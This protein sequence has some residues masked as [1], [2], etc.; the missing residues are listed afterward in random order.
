MSKLLNLIFIFIIILCYYHIKA[1][2][3]IINT[4]QSQIKAYQQ[5]V[6]K[7]YQKLKKQNKY[8]K[9]IQSEN[10][11]LKWKECGYYADYIIF[12]H[13]QYPDIDPD[14]VIRLISKES[15]WNTWASS[16]IAYGLTQVNYSTWYKAYHLY[17]KKQL[18]NPFLNIEIG[19]DILNHYYQRSSSLKQALKKYSGNTTSQEYYAYIIEGGKDE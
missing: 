14:I 19:V 2:K 5:L 12:I 3:E 17:S 15:S 10:N 1:D 13:Q 9:L 4:Q 18:Y 11:S 16:G 7:H 6:N 8:A